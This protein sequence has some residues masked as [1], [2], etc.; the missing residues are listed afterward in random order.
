MAQTL[1]SHSIDNV[2]PSSADPSG[3]LHSADAMSLPG[4][5]A[6]SVQAECDVLWDAICDAKKCLHILEA[7]PDPD[8]TSDTIQQLHAYDAA[9]L[10]PFCE[11][12]TPPELPMSLP[13]T[14]PHT[15]HVSG[16]TQSQVT[17]ALQPLILQVDLT[18]IMQRLHS[19]THRHPRELASIPPSPAIDPRPPDPSSIHQSPVSAHGSFSLIKL[20]STVPTPEITGLAPSPVWTAPTNHHYGPIVAMRLPTI[21]AIANE[22]Q[23]PSDADVLG[24]LC[25]TFEPLLFKDF[26]PKKFAELPPVEGI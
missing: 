19:C 26:F 7:V 11:T 16:Y 20:T 18:N 17:L 15:T 4:H 8:S 1:P 13:F 25:V 5:D 3:P 21:A 14:T 24:A 6:T 23:D 12:S 2:T 9:A 10:Q 22:I